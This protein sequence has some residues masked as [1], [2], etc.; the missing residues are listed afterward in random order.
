MEFEAFFEEGSDETMLKD[1]V[2]LSQLRP[3]PPPPPPDFFH[4]IDIG[5]PLELYHED[6]WWEVELQSSKQAADGGLTFK[7]VSPLYGTERWAT[8]ER[9]RPRWRFVL[10]R[11][12]GEHWMAAGNSGLLV[13]DSNLTGQPELPRVPVSGR[14]ESAEL[15]DG[16]DAVEHALASAAVDA[17]ALDA[18][19]SGAAASGAEGGGGGE[20][21]GV[22]GDEQA[23]L[24]WQLA[25]LHRL[26]CVYREREAEVR[27]AALR[28]FPLAH[29]AVVNAGGTL[30]QPECLARGL[31]P[32]PPLPPPPAFQ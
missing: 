21:S 25:T 1:W 26:A 23:Q 12:A 13:W 6:G 24:R 20:G 22:E 15:E 4:H 8:T 28:I 31:P 27:R 3:Q 10:S 2:S 9:L 16:E 11:S 32:L 30:E 14:P 18:A 17:A 19:W 5:E 7:V 29:S